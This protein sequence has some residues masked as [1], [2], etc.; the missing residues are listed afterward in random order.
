MN[1][2]PSHPA[3]IKSNPRL[4]VVDDD[5]SSGL[6]TANALRNEFDAEVVMSHGESEAIRLIKESVFTV[7]IADLSNPNASGHHVRAYLESH[8]EIDCYFIAYTGSAIPAELRQRLPVILKPQLKEL[9]AV[10]TDLEIPR[11]IRR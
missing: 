2:T 11:R 6:S 8:R 5:K 1:S 9:V 4:L 7:V 10:L 3:H